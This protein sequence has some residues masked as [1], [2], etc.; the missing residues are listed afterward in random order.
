MTQ[1]FDI[2]NIP[3]ED[4]LLVDQEKSWL[5]VLTPALGNLDRLKKMLSIIECPNSLAKNDRVIL[6]GNFLNDNYENSRQMLEFLIT[7]KKKRPNV[8]VPLLGPNEQRFT[9]FKTSLAKTSKGRSILDQY[10]SGFFLFFFFKDHR[11]F[12]MDL[13]QAYETDSFFI[14]QAGINPLDSLEKQSSF[15]LI[16]GCKD[17]EDSTQKFGKKI[18]A[19]GKQ[20][21]AK[22]YDNKIL[23]PANEKQHCI[24]LDDNAK[25]GKK[26][27]QKMF[28]LQ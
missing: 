28:A 6:M 23:L 9:C 4:D 15:F 21:I 3:D 18:I 26:D 8:F 14:S 20:G 22:F 16:Y 2:K 1:P 17:F 12:L 5:Y 19:M 27:L 24:I 25:E 13:P 10:S 7:Y 11:K